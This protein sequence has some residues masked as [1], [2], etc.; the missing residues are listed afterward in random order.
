MWFFQVQ[1]RTHFVWATCSLFVLPGE[2]ERGMQEAGVSRMSEL[3]LSLTIAQSISP[4]EAGDTL[5]SKLHVYCLLWTIYLNTGLSV[6]A[7]TLQLGKEDIN[8]VISLYHQIHGDHIYSIYLP[9]PPK[10]VF[11]LVSILKSKISLSNA[12][13]LIQNTPGILYLEAEF[14]L[15]YETLKLYKSLGFQICLL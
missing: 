11:I 14:L 3:W 10:L 5:Q 4:D 2:K 15:S 1:V 8:N 7:S 6:S 12:H 13:H 9:E